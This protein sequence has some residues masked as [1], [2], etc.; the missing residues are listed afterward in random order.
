MVDAGWIY[1]WTED[2]VE[3][4]TGVE[5]KKKLC[6]NCLH[7]APDPR[8]KAKMWAPC[9]QRIVRVWIGNITPP[10]GFGCVW[11]QELREDADDQ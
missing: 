9:Q 11:W 10:P 6:R 1:Q 2:Y 8:K 5:E 3:E 7:W 4:T